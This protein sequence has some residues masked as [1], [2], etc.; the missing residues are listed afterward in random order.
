M[1][2]A[3]PPKARPATETTHDETATPATTDEPGA[4]QTASGQHGVVVGGSEHRGGRGELAGDGALTGGLV[5]PSQGLP[6][7]LLAGED[8][9]RVGDGLRVGL[10]AHLLGQLGRLGEDAEGLLQAD[11]VALGRQVLLAPLPRGH[12]VDEPEHGDERQHE[13]PAPRPD[14]HADEGMSAGAPR[15]RCGGVCLRRI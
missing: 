1:A 8:A 5:G 14:V 3:P 11:G 13:A 9:L 15:S 10:D 7:G 12:E 4:A 6:L 2:T